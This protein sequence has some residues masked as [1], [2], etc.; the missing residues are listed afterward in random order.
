MPPWRCA[1]AT[2]PRTSYEADGSLP[3]IRQVA[4]SQGDSMSIPSVPAGSGKHPIL[5]VTI[6]ANDL[7]AS[8]T[9]YSKVFKWQTHEVTS[10]IA[11]AATPG[12]PGVAF[13]S[14][15]PRGFP[16]LVPFIGVEDMESARQRARTPV[17]QVQASRSARRYFIADARRG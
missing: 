16:S 14:D 6:S 17:A 8:M 7:K 2:H 1:G 3:E 12:G 13:R 10:T 9:F 4:G 5:L 11:G 15:S